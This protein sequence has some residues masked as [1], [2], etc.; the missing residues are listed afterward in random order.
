MN[1]HAVLGVAP[2]ATPE[3]IKSA[4]R[5]LAMT[6]HP[7]R[8]GGS[9]E[10]QKKFQEIQTAY[11]MLR[12][13]KPKQRAADPDAQSVHEAQMHMHEI[14]EHF[15]GQ[16]RRG[17]P[18]IQAH[19]AISLEQAFNGCTVSFNVNGNSVAVNIPAGIDH[20][21]MLR[22]PG[23]AG[24]PNPDF[25][26]G[27]LHVGVMMHPHEKFQRH[28]M[29]LITRIRIDL[30]DLITGCEIEVPLITGG[31]KTVTVPANSS[32]D[33]AVIVDGE[34]MPVMRTDQRGDLMVHFE[35]TY[36]TFTEQQLKTLRKMKKKD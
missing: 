14:F 7:D 11:D 30:L 36:P 35:V 13:D 6:H 12:S 4:Y 22:V 29:T 17:N 32:P 2:D 27:D 5:K 9:E 23:G 26:A 21:Q 19:C 15:F 8:N 16:Q 1:A 25:P 10:S 20:G 33:S 3:Q 34:G 28:G 18:T 31:T 24:Q